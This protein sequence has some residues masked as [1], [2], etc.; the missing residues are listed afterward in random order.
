MENVERKI[1][2]RV[3]GIISIVLSAAVFTAALAVCIVYCMLSDAAFKALLVPLLIVLTVA[4]GLTAFFAVLNL[5]S[6]YGK[7]SFGLNLG[8][9]VCVIIS[10][11]QLAA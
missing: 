8:S 10:F 7:I 2:R 3:M 1:Y 4:A 5:D 11:I 9:A 6:V